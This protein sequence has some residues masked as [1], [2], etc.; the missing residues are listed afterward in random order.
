MT[1]EFNKKVN[2]RT[3]KVGDLVLR[4]MEAL[5]RANEQGKV[6]PNWEGPYK[7]AEVIREGT[8]GLET[9]EGK[10]LPRTWNADKLKRYYL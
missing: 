5:G 9:L 8:F 2:P 3:F 7:I 6:T 4:K 10:W 1:R